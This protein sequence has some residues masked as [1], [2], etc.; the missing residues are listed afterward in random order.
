MPHR[1]LNGLKTALLLGVLSAVIVA[2]GSL[3]GRGGIVIAAVLALGMN[4][5]SYFFSDRLALRA[6][7]AYPVS[8]VQQPRL[9][10]IVQELATRA[11]MPMPRL[12]LSPTSSPNAFATGRN[13][14]NAA[15]CCTEGILEI[16]DDRELRGVLGHELS[17]VYNR[18]I[19]I[20]SVAGALAGI[21]VYFANMMQVFAFFGGGRDEEGPGL[22]EM[23]ALIVVGP[24]AAT[25]IQLAISRAREYQADESGSTLTGDPLGLASALRK[26]EAGTA[27]RPLPADSRLGPASALMIANPFRGGGVSRFFSTHPPIAERVARLEERA[28]MN[29]YQ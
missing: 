14:R 7:R 27:A 2:V 22:V 3:F 8:Q 13:P 21:I 24:I 23:L 15:V 5:F 6:M 10:A 4:G 9:Y 18:D 12:Y 17:H 1:S 25:I 19:L 16:M 28:R 20:A 29:P 26:L 11:R